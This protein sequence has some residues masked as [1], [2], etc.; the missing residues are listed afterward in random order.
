[1]AHANLWRRQNKTQY[2]QDPLLDYRANSVILG[3][4]RARRKLGIFAF[5]NNSIF[6]VVSEG[7][8]LISK[9]FDMW[10]FFCINV[11]ERI[12]LENIDIVN[13]Q[14]EILLI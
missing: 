10:K 5:S 7:N 2:F 4:F 6:C 8:I 1:M 13:I 12:R 11:M 3:V 9:L 14:S